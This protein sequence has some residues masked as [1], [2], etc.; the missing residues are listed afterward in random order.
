MLH[1]KATDN[2]APGRQST[3]TL[4]V[5]GG[6]RLALANAGAGDQ[7]A[8]WDGL[9]VALARN[10]E[11]LAA[12]EWMQV[13]PA[14]PTLKTRDNRTY[15]LP[16][17]QVLVDAFA[18]N[19]ADLP[20]DLNHASEIKGPKGEDAPAQGWVKAIEKRPDGTTWC[21]V[22]WTAEGAAQVT[23]KR[24]RYVS[25][26]FLYT[27]AGQILRVTSVALVTQPAL[28]MPALA[29]VEPGPTQEPEMSSTLLATLVAALG[30]DKATTEPDLITHI[31]GQVALAR[32]ARDPTKLAP[33]ADLTA[34]LA[35]ATT[36]E[37]ALATIQTAT[38]EAAVAAA[39]DAAMAEG[40][41]LPASRDHWLAV[42]RA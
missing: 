16:D 18:R 40:K 7:V 11:A 13:F 33:V 23:S 4:V 31:T 28:D 19:N 17:P 35:R 30:L 34:A 24:Y 26:A 5:E 1:S 3:E 12:P 14:G 2:R 32:E 20:V 15:Q 39:V 8:F 38:K 42:A 10:G 27:A 21:R 37:T 9:E 25:P 41:V 29:R 6:L 36:A 22:D